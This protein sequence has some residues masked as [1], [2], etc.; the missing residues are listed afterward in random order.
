MTPAA[1]LSATIEVLDDIIARRRPAADALKDWGLAHRFAGSGD[2][3]AIGSLTFDA[4][5][6]RASS[7]W[8]MGDESPRAIALGMLKRERNFNLAAIEKL[9][10][11]GRFAPSPLSEDERA[12]LDTADVSS[13]PAWV[14]GDYPE[15]LDPYLT[16]SF[17]DDRAEEGAA[18]A[19]RA[20]VDLRANL[21]KSDAQ[22]VAAELAE[23]HAQPTRWSPTGVR[24]AL[25]SD[26]KAPPLQSEPGYLKGMFEVQDE[27]S[28][29]A[30]LFAAPE[31][32]KR[33]IDLCA[34]AGGKSLALAA[35]MHNRGEVIATDSD[36]RRLAPIYARL[37]RASAKCVKVLTPRGKTDV[38]AEFD[39]SAD[40]VLVDAPCTGSGAWRRNPDAKWRIRPGALEIREREQAEVLDRAARLVR[41]G[42]RLA[43]VTCSVLDNENGAQVRSFLSRSKSFSV[44][45]PDEVISALGERAMV[46]GK[47]ARLSAE[48]ILMTPRTTETDGFFVS[49]LRREG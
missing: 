18:L 29:L 13:A 1:R 45:L 43:Y 4:L 23:Y 22:K 35:L 41:P 40:L 32:G 12:R 24:I 2:R 31:G 49:V 42:G 34:G 15:W 28:Q 48:G 27:G 33:V 16:A 3:A 14:A 10:D 21:I 25:G 7:A 44:I 19:A 39:L 5:R 20:P 38:L 30:A 9:T 8:I 17:G 36:K 11:G 47:A 37:E 46:F 26:A 6:K